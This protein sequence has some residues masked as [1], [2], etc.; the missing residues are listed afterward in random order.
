MLRRDVI[1]AGAAAAFG[2]AAVRLGGG[3]L[4]A[5][6]GTGVVA[7]ALLLY[8]HRPWL[9]SAVAVT[10]LLLTLVGGDPPPDVA[11]LLAG[12]HAFFTARHVG[13]G[14]ALGL[15]V[16]LL[17]LVEVRASS[18]NQVPI[19]FVIVGPFLAGHALR[20]RHLVARQLQERASELEAERDVYADLSVRYE[21][22][23]IAAELHDI[24]AHAISVMVVQASAGQRLA[25]V[26]PELAQ[27]AFSAIAGAARQAESD[28]ARL[29]RLLADEPPEGDAEDLALVRELVSRAAGTGLDVSL[30]V[31]G[32][33]TL[34]LHGPARRSAYL[35]VREGLTN[36]LRYASGAPVRVLVDARPRELV[37][38]V[39]NAAAGISP[40]LAGQG[41]GTGLRGLREHLDSCGGRLEAGRTPDGGWRL[42]ARVPRAVRAVP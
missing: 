5:C 30:R 22:A 20:G 9:A 38:D 23:R 26:D 36:A 42:R 14:L 25:I 7:A 41:S 19:L 16:A 29:V 40:L 15:A 4:S 8:H 32:D 35:V 31:E 28:M 24:V 13:G 12:A 3:E 1:A 11:G 39:V 37:V 33:R 18:G 17:A 10:G 2:A 27:E 21:R 34:L 6:V